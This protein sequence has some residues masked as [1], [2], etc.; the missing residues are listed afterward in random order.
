MVPTAAPVLPAVRS[1]LG[2]DWV[3]L[4]A[5]VQANQCGAVQRLLGA[6]QVTM[7]FTCPHGLF[8]LAAN[9]PWA[10]CDGVACWLGFPPTAANGELLVHQLDAEKCL[11]PLLAP[12]SL[13][14]NADR[15]VVI[16]PGHGGESPGTR[17]VVTGQPEKHY[18]LDWAQR[19]APLLEAKGWRVVLTR[20]NDVELSLPERAAIAD[21]WQ[22]TLFISLHFNSTPSSDLQGIETF[23]LTPTG[24]PST[25][26]REYED[27]ATRVFPNNAYDRENV[28]LAFRLH[29]ALLAATDAGDRGVRRARFMGVL[30]PQQRPAVLI[31]GGYLSNPEEAQRIDTAGYRQKLAEAIAQALTGRGLALDAAT[32]STPQTSP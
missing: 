1:A 14:S 18:A 13:P 7:E 12:L 2:V 29:R 31:E 25:I 3:S 6:S 16:D 27:D 5:W 19:L 17:S 26:T 8:R 28:A 10:Y 32:A 11:H 30:R 20:T 24:M 23:C 4:A 21:R 15:L 9:S 22:A